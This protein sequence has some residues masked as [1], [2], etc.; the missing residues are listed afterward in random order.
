MGLFSL[1]FGRNRKATPSKRGR[2]AKFIIKRA[3]NKDYYFILQ[4]TN[5]KTIVVSEMYKTKQ[6]AEVGIAAVQANCNSCIIED[7][8]K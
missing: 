4:A 1:L 7:A 5:G 6:G 2:Q 3:S 8:S